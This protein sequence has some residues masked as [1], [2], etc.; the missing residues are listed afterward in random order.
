MLQSQTRRLH[1]VVILLFTGLWLLTVGVP[2]VSADGNES[3]SNRSLQGAYGFLASGTLNG[4]AAIAVGRYTFNGDGTCTQ[5]QTVNVS[6]VT[7][8]GVGPIVATSCTY[9]VQPDGTGTITLDVP[10]FGAFH[11]AFVI[12]DKKKELQLITLDVDPGG[13]IATLQAKKQ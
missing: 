10:G 4:N 7:P 12:V 6:G 2:G 13:V 1:G 9:A 8:G 3:F 11:L 5:S